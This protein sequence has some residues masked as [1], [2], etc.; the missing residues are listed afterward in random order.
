MISKRLDPTNGNV[1][2][3]YLRY[4]IPWSLGFLMLSSAGL[5]DAIFIGR[6]A[7]ATALAGVNVAGPIISF[8]NCLG[9]MLAVGGTVATAKFVGRGNIRSACTMFSRTMLGLLLVGLSFAVLALLFLDQVVALLGARE[10]LIAPTRTYV[11]T[12][13]LFGPIMPCSFALAQF[14]RVDEHPTLA[15]FGLGVT[16]AVNISLDALFIGLLDWGVLGAALATGIGFTCS[17]LLLLTHFLS[18]RSRLRFRWPGKGWR[19]LLRTGRNGAAAALNEFSIGTIIVVLNHLMFAQFGA[20]GVAAYTVVNYGAWFG[21][22]LAFGMSDTLSPLVSANLGARKRERIRALLRVGLKTLLVIGVGILLVFTFWP[23]Q[24]ID[25][26]VPGNAPVAAI[27]LDFIDVYRWNFIF[28]SINMGLIC[29]F[30]GLHLSSQALTVAMLR[31]L[32]MRLVLLMALPPLLG[33]AGI[34][35]ALPLAE[36]LTLGVAVVLML[37][38]RRHLDTFLK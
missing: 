30:T 6:C 24:I 33:V 20:N 13:M 14:A 5:V 4:G 2:K 34:Y 15:S 32:I 21:L 3:I 12:L 25:L 19:V 35:A 38:A 18:S 17:G 10:E 29:F 16:A 31:S 23:Q 8:F 22:T 28:S 11:R 7:G 9:I 1:W 26:F 27:A 37:K 36:V